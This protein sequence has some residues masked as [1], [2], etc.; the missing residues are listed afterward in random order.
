MLFVSFQITPR[1]ISAHAYVNAAFVL[2]FDPATAKI[3]EKPT[4]L[5]GGI[6]DRFV[7]TH[8]IDD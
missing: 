2:P 8:W 5:L 6:S 1:A 4:L 7:S 3:T